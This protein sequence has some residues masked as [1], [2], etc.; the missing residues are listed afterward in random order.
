[1]SKQDTHFYTTFS[2]VLGMLVLFTVLMFMLATFIHG[3][4]EAHH[5][6]E[7]PRKLAQIKGNIAPIATVAVKGENT[8]K[9]TSSM[10]NKSPVPEKEPAPLSVQSTAPKPAPAAVTTSAQSNADGKRV[11]QQACMACHGAGVAGAPKLGDSDAWVSRIKKGA[12]ALYASSIN[13]IGLMPAK[14]GNTSLSDDDVRSAV[15]YMIEAV[16]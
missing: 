16:Q 13:G 7:E 10:I 11:Y 15:D 1:M 14:G 3:K 8:T 4:T 2:L 9:A 5:I 12:Q 6:M